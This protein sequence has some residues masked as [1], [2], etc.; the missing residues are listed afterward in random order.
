MI[1]SLMSICRLGAARAS[2]GS[3]ASTRRHCLLLLSDGASTRQ[4]VNKDTHRVAYLTS[5]GVAVV[6]LLT[7]DDAAL[8]PPPRHEFDQVLMEPSNRVEGLLVPHL[9]QP[10]VVISPYLRSSSAPT[11]TVSQLPVGTRVDPSHQPHSAPRYAVAV[12]PRAAALTW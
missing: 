1:L 2:D 6:L 9:R 11:Q 5:D 8:A 12:A 4:R 3:G 7:I 10:K